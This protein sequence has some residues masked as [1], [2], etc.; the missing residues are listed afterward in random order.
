LIPKVNPNIIDDQLID[1]DYWLFGL[2]PSVWFQSIM[3]P[4]FTEIFEWSYLSYYFLPLV[5]PFALFLAKKTNRISEYLT[6]VLTAFYLSYF[7]YLFFPA[8]GPRFF[9]AHLHT[10]PLQGI[11]LAEAIQYTLNNM[12]KIQLDAFPSGHATII[13]ILM[14]YSWK[15]VRRLFWGILPICVALVISTVYLRLHYVV[16]IVAGLILTVMVIWVL[17]YIL[18]RFSVELKTG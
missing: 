8:Y 1:L 9:L 4:F 16:D 5:V 11:W 13:F 3:H 15:H 18:K 17:K 10:E 7:G 14:Y 12:E 6:I 2:H